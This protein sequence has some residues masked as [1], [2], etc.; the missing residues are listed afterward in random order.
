M[1]KPGGKP[2]HKVKIEWSPRFAYAIGLIATDGCLYS[3]GRHMNFTSKD[4]DLAETF[5]QC[6]RLKV[7]IGRKKS[8]FTSKDSYCHV[9]FGDVVFHRWLCSIGITP[10]KS[11]TLNTLRVPR[12][13]FF[14][15][16]RGSF[17]GDGSIYSYWDKRWKSSFMFYVQFTSASLHHLEWLQTII[18]RHLGVWGMIGPVNG[19]HQLRYAKSGSRKLLSAMYYD[20][21]LPWLE[22]KRIKVKRILAI[23]SRDQIDTMRV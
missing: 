14:D 23:D 22:R 11:K 2:Q 3:D 5:I 21:S 1:G 17:D 16:L 12:K 9:Q 7:K 20:D 6:L 8:G 13:Y 4:R 15:F 10:R 18:D 19:A